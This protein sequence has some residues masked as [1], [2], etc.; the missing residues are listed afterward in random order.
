MIVIDL[1]APLGRNFKGADGRCKNIVW[2]S[3]LF[4]RR[5]SCRN[6]L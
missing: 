2:R 1:I 3:V 5:Y 4:T 6:H